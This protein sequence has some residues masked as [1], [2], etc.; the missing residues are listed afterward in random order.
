M[1]QAKGRWLAC[2]LSVLS[3]GRSRLRLQSAADVQ[4]LA[5][6][7]SRA[8]P[9]RARGASWGGEAEARCEQAFLSARV[10]LLC[11]GSDAHGW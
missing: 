5:G 6:D 9:G 2:L 4:A 10:V 1:G 3:S 7:Q 8:R 11:C